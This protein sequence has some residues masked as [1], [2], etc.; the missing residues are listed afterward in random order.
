MIIKEIDPK[1]GNHKMTA[2]GIKAEKQMAFYLKRS[3]GDSEEIHVIN[4]LRLGYKGEVAQFDHL[5]VHLIH[6]LRIDPFP[7]FA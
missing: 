6:R 2:A 5:I 1:T 3:F 4:D 7:A